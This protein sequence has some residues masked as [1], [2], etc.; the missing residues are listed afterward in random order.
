MTV[1]SSAELES[2]LMISVFISVQAQTRGAEE[3]DNR[4]APLLAIIAFA[5]EAHQHRQQPP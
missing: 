2:S 1:R 4:I 3:P 5:E